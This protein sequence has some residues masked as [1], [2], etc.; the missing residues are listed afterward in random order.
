MRSVA[1]DDAGDWQVSVAL[2]APFEVHAETAGYARRQRRQQHL[3][4]VLAF[5]HRAGCSVGVGRAQLAATSTGG[6]HLAQRPQGAGYDGLGALSGREREIAG[7]VADGAS[8]LDIARSLFLSRKTVEGHVSKVRDH[9]RTAVRSCHGAG[10]SYVA[11][12]AA[13]WWIMSHPPGEAFVVSSAPTSAQVRA[14]LWRHGRGAI[15]GRQ[16]RRPPRTSANDPPRADGFLVASLLAASA[17]TLTVLVAARTAQALAA[18]LVLPNSLARVHAS[19]PGRLGRR[20]GVL[21]AI[22]TLAAA[23]GPALDRTRAVACPRRAGVGLTGPALQTSALETTHP[24]HAGVAA[25]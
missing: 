25:A 19:F 21:A 8:N 5:D 6:A 1:E 16:A 13:V 2:D 23:A 7:L 10:K 12:R 18:G 11:A 15:G 14:I 22:M 3:V 20:V 17:P 24:A 4:D 9:R